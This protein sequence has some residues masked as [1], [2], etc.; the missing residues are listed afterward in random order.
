MD[1][2]NK[3]IYNDNNKL[4]CTEYKRFQTYPDLL[5]DSKSELKGNSNHIA[6]VLIPVSKIEMSMPVNIGDYTDFY[7]SREHA[8]NVGAMFRGK[9][10]ALQPNW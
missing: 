1:E 2:N 7:A 10:N 6:Q 4:T 9:D 8:A 5:N 3:P